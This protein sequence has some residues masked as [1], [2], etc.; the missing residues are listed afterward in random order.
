MTA[1][2]VLSSWS[3]LN[4]ST[5]FQ[6]QPRSKARSCDVVSTSEA[7]LSVA[8][9]EA[10]PAAPSLVRTVCKFFVNTGR[11][12]TRDCS[13]AHDVAARG[14]WVAERQRERRAAAQLDSERLG[15]PHAAAV[16][17]DKGRRAAIFADW[18]VATFGAEA[19]N[20]G[21]GV[22]DVAG[23]RGDLSFELACARGVRCVLV[24]PR[25]QQPRKQH[26]KR[27]ARSGGHVALPR[28]V[29]SC[30]G[31]EFGAVSAEE[32]EVLRASSAFVGMH[33]DEATEWIVDT[34]L[35]ERR[36]FA[37]VPCCVFA[38][39]FARRTADGRSVTTYEA[40]L[41]YLLAKD[42]S[43]QRD[44]LPFE[45][46]NCVLYRHA[47]EPA[48]AKPTGAPVS[49]AQCEACEDDLGGACVPDVSATTETVDPDS[50]LLGNAGQVVA[51][52]RAQRHSCVVSRVCDT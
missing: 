32:R 38:D 22:C 15:D 26:W 16:K 4:P 21:T 12:A 7:P 8:A 35:R 37:V 44:W 23:G 40:F 6:P 3:E 14:E 1:I 24:D 41:A 34:A 48:P 43:I 11:C 28:H 18:L 33:P 13:F 42:P 27:L 36:P 2:T 52:S 20:E 49:L 25:P 5:P 50:R 46:R 47:D 51:K 30:V 19:L 39:L 10:P 29:Q 31:P 45:G 9:S 17:G